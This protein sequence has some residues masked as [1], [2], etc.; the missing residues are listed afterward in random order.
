MTI[1]AFVCSSCDTTIYSRCKDDVC[2][3]QCGRAS[4]SNGYEFPIVTVNNEQLVLPNL[5]TIE[6]PRVDPDILFWDWNLMTGEYGYEPR[7]TY[8]N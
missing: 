8:T 3:C 1:N 2:E 7:H 4:I 6:E 5:I